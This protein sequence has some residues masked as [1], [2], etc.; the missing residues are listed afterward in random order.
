MFG[1][2]QPDTPYLFVKDDT[3]YKALYCG[4]CKAIGS[5]CSQLAR[6]S[7]TYD[8]AFLSAVAH[9]VCNVDVT[10]KR[11]RCIAHPIKSRPIASCDPLTE[12]LAAIN[13]IL[14]EYKVKDDVYDSGKGRFKGLIIGGGYKKAKR[15]YPEIDKIVSDGYYSLFEKE[16]QGEKS[17]DMVCDPFA[18]LLA[19]LSD[20]VFGEY[21]T[22][23]THK[24]FYAIG[25]W[26]YLIDALD[27]FEKDVKKK[28]YN[29]FV[30]AYGETDFVQFVKNH[31]EEVN[32]IF[33]S[34]FSTISEEAEKIKFYFNGD[35]VKNILTRGIPEAYK[36]VLKI[37]FD[38]INTKGRQSDG[39]NA[40]H[41]AKPRSIE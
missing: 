34:V 20:E 33:S 13:V 12:K 36:R 22:E 32:F 41:E 18:E 31:G 6:M 14:S 35:L 29:L 7:L 27:D 5:S 39:E 11:E 3:L 28:N 8:I 26:I 25:K 23:S 40:N 10:L 24:L 2:I 17:V 9:N 30:T 16:K 37:K 21:A 1:Y 15:K 19:K 38:K 4:V